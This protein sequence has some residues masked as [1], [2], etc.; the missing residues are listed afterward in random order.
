M[1]IWLR[2]SLKL[3]EQNRNKN[4][5]SKMNFFPHELLLVTFHQNHTKLSYFFSF[6]CFK[7]NSLQIYLMY[8]THTHTHTEF[9]PTATKEKKCYSFEF[10]PFNIFLLFIIV[11]FWS[12]SSTKD[13]LIFF[14]LLLFPCALMLVILIVQHLNVIFISFYMFQRP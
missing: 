5:Q 3:R 13:F 4:C 2:E 9:D 7:W 6:S 14:N 12:D 10:S 1:I 11:A 8:Q